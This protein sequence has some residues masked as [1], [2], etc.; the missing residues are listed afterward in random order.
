MKKILIL[1]MVLVL[2]LSAVGAGYATWSKDLYVNG[3][4]VT[5]NVAAV[6]VETGESDDET[7]DV[8]S[9][10]CEVIGDMLYVDVLNAYPGVTYTNSFTVTST[11]SVPVHVYLQ[12]VVEPGIGVHASYS[13]AVMG[14]VEDPQYPGQYIPGLVP[15]TLPVQLHEGDV[16]Y[17]LITVTVDQGYLEEGDNMGQSTGFSSTIYCVQYNVVP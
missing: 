13:W 16:L 3:T 4:V 10:S 2:A 8:S 9:I 17:G 7:K 14:L 15:A 5:G 1:G 6:I 11:G 12:D